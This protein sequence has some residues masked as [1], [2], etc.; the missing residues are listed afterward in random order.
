MEP[1]PSAQQRGIDARLVAAIEDVK[2]L[3]IGEH[4]D[5]VLAVPAVAD[6]LE[7]VVGVLECDARLFGFDEKAHVAE[8]RRE[9]K[10]VVGFLVRRALPL[11]ALDF[12]FLLVGVFL[13]DVI[14]VPAERDEKLVDEIFARLSFVVG[15]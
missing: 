12:D 10:C 2:L 8:V 14:H 13:R 4:G 5:E 15:G 6:G 9:G 3:E 11:C 1:F 7:I